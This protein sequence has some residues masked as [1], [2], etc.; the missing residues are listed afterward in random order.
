MTSPVARRYALALATEAARA[1]TVDAVDADLAAIHETAQQSP[2]LGA[3]LASPVV[4]REAKRRIVDAVF[5]G[6][7]E[8]T[9]RFVDLLFA[10]EREAFVTGVAEAYQ[11]LRD[12]QRGI[13]EATVRVPS[14]MS[15]A[16]EAALTSALEARTG[17][18]VRLRT[19]VDASL[20][21]GIVVRIGDTVYDGSARQQLAQLHERLLTGD[22]RLA[23]DDSAAPSLN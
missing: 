17:K 3:A 21:G 5:P 7:S 20:L 11:A 22:H 15:A 16:D 19:S 13:V 8:T 2:D 23:G 6:L 1:D 4:S 18:T 12:D 10:K 9:R 14:E